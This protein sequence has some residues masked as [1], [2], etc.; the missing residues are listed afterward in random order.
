MLYMKKYFL[1]V[2]I[3]FI[4]FWI[5][6]IS[7]AY[8]LN[9]NDK[10]LVNNV[11]IKVE[12][13]IEKKW[14][15]VRETF[16]SS[17][18][19]LAI[20]YKNQ[21]RLET[22]LLQIVNNLDNNTYQEFSEEKNNEFSCNSEKVSINKNNYWEVEKVI[23]SEDWKEKIVYTKKW[24]LE[25]CN[26]PW[27]EK[28]I[29]DYY[30]FYYK[31]DILIESKSSKNHFELWFLDWKYKYII[32]H[33]NENSHLEFKDKNYSIKWIINSYSANSFIFSWEKDKILF[34]DWT[35]SDEY[36]QIFNSKELD[37]WDNVL[38]IWKGK[39]ATWM[40]EEF[41]WDY[42]IVNNWIET[43]IWN[44]WH[45]ENLVTCGNEYWYIYWNSNNEFT[46]NFWW[47]NYWIDKKTNVFNFYWF[48]KN[49]CIP[50]YVQIL[51]DWKWEFWVNQLYLWDELIAK[52]D[53]NIANPKINWSDLYYE[54]YEANWYKLYKNSNKI[55]DRWWLNKYWFLENGE[56]VYATVYNWDT[57]IK[58]WNNEEIM[59]WIQWVDYLY[60]SGD[61]KDYAFKLRWNSQEWYYTQ[62]YYNWKIVKNKNK[63]VSAMFIKNNLISTYTNS[64]DTKSYLYNNNS[65]ITEFS[66]N[67]YII[68]DE[69]KEFNK[70]DFTLSI[71]WVTN[72]FKCE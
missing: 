63:F 43:K 69:Q 36:D 44:K 60:I 16:V 40:W 19:K 23:F 22:I 38:V 68:P 9:S 45:I 72:I 48:K 61:W 50:I 6:N 71:D 12:Q 18:K 41:E 14:E 62:L 67:P 24:K 56:L 3:F 32:S 37:N 13:I 64:D 31:D 33:E 59:P 27:G 34:I 52:S 47:K 17:I 57:I 5:K 28:F 8:D 46:F 4:I 65:L 21:P 49:T 1:S 20:K 25:S 55:E 70:F 7:F 39:K 51:D 53:W 30:Y 42:Y 66:W 26:C 11:T 2:I 10:I 15:Y 54:I 35:F 58:K 29:W